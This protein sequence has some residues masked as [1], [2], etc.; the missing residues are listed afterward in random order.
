MDGNK[1]FEVGFSSRKIALIETEESH[2]TK[3]SAT[4]DSQCRRAW[5]WS[6]L[7]VVR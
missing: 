5:G 7:K 1:T 6:S 4:N 2:P 3:A